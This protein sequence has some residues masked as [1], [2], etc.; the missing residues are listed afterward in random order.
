M[1]KVILF[2][3]LCVFFQIAYSQCDKKVI[4]KCSK[5]RDFKNGSV[6]QEVSLDAS[7]SLDNN[8]IILTAS[9]N[10]ETET[11]ESDITEVSV[12]DWPDFLKNGKA[13]YKAM[14]KKGN[15]N[16]ENSI[17]EIESD[18]GYT[19][20]TFSSDPDTGSKLQFDVA[21]YT[22]TKDASPDNSSDKPMKRSKKTKRKSKGTTI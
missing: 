5:A 9:M 12:C 18:N 17:I 1:K 6:G 22:I 16:V 7:I 4:F 19:K 2:V 14:T 15:G 13:R 21:E 10:G 11:L 3:G 20:I 8:K